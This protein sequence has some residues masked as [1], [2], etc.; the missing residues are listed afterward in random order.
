MNAT[1]P[2][3]RNWIHPAWFLLFL[4]PVLARVVNFSPEFSDLGLGAALVEWVLALLVVMPMV[5]VR[6]RG[7]GGATHRFSK[8]CRMHLSGCLLAFIGP[9]IGMLAPDG[10]A[11]GFVLYSYA[12]GCVLMAAF[13]FGR[14]FEQRTLGGLLAQPISRSRLFLEKLAAPGYLI[15]LASANLVLLLNWRTPSAFRAADLSIASVLL[16]MAVCSAP[17]FS[18]VSRGTLPGAVFA[19]AM[20]PS[21]WILEAVLVR[22]LEAR[23]SVDWVLQGRLHVVVVAVGMTV[24]CV[25]SL[26]LAWRCWSRLQLDKDGAGGRGSVALHPMSDPMDSLLSSI[27][28]PSDWKSQLIRKEARLHVIPWLIAAIMVGLWALVVVLRRVFPDSPE[29]AWMVAGSGILALTGMLSAFAILGAGAAVVAEE[30]ELGTLEWQITQPITL[31]RQWWIKVFVAAMAAIL[32]GVLLPA[33]LLPACLGLGRIGELF[34]GMRTVEWIGHAG[35]GVLLFVMAVYASS[36][37][38]ST[39]S[40]AL[41]AVGLMGLVLTGIVAGV[42]LPTPYLLMA[43]FDLER[44]LEHQAWL[45]AAFG[46]SPILLEFLVI[47]G[48]GAMG[49][50]GGVLWLAGRNF[51]AAP[52]S[53][54]FVMRQIAGVVLAGMLVV[55][56][57]MAIIL[58]IINRTWGKFGM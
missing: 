35:L 20:P 13:A 23:V 9:G 51:R 52:K 57:L 1:L 16:V 19:L 39:V 50:L 49:W 45:L 4:P 28:S 54:R 15:G 7:A 37:C 12:L 55:Y 32:V 31:W 10:G 44:C 40:A 24:Y 46:G 42:A 48:L 29:W 47:L 56:L 14:E 8:E 33:A 26:F 25:S 41:A 6:W 38:R 3:Y 18:I 43:Y 22:W 27:L 53:L 30:R 21:L 11:M 58:P 2:F 34:Q 5:W 36:V 17:F